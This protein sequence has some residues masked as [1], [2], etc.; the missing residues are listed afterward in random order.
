[1]SLLTYHLSNENL[2]RK[3][4]LVILIQAPRS[5]LNKEMLLSHASGPSEKAALEFL[6]KSQDRTL[7]KGDQFYIPADRS[8]DVLKMLGTTGRLFYQNKKIVIDPFISL[9]LYF[10]TDEHVEGYWKTGNQSGKISECTFVFAADPSWM[11]QDSI[12]RAFSE[13][14]GSKWVRL[15]LEGPKLLTGP[16]LAEFLAEAEGE[17]LIVRK[18]PLPTVADPL[19]V[20]KLVDR[21]GGFANLWFD[22]GPYGS[23]VSHDSSSTP[24]R[25]G[26]AERAWERDLLE[27][28]FQA[29]IVDRSHY[30]C[31]LDK[32]TKSLT[33]L[34]EI[35]WTIFDAQDRKVI[36]QKHCDLDAEITKEHIIVKARLHY[37]QHQVNLKDVVGAFNRR[38]HFVE[39]SSD[40]VA[41]IDRQEIS[42][43][44]GDLMDQ[45]VTSEGIAVKKNRFGLLAP[46]FEGKGWQREDLKQQI[47]QLATAQPS[48]PIALTEVFKGTLFPYQN[49]GL[50]WLHFLQEGRFGG[51][52]ADEM[53]LGKTVQVLAFFSSLKFERP[54]LIV[55]PTSLIFNWHS[56]IEKFLPT[57]QVYRH[58]GKDRLRTKEELSRCSLILTSY[59]LMRIDAS[60][61]QELDYD[62]IVLDEGQT[63]KNPDSQI[64][65]L[66]CQLKADM[67][68]VI[69]GTPIENKLEDIWSLFRFL[70]PDLLGERRSF[71]AEIL[72]AQSDS[73]YL[74]RLKRKIRP[75][76]LRRKK[77]QV[78]LQLPPKLEQTILVEMNED[79]RQIYERWLQNTRKGLLKKVD[80]EGIAQ[81]R[82]EILE[83]IL[84][85]R[86]LCAHPWLIEER[87]E[88]DPRKLS[89]K[90]E[91][92]MTDLQ[93]VM[94]EGSK[95]LVY[96][97]FT[98]MLRLIEQEVK[99]QNWKYV[100]LDGSSAHREQTVRQFQEDP[101]TAIFLISL[102]AGGV[103]LNLTAADYVFLYDPWWNEAVEKQAIDRAHRLGKRGTV[104][105]RR[106]IT[107]LS[108]EEKMM[109]LKTKKTALA[110]NFLDSA[111]ELE[112]VSLEDLLELLN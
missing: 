2:N 5:I 38:E 45:E 21:H 56:E 85:L 58:E 81:H 61:L 44:W 55:V 19:P 15:A 92:L 7:S 77:E 63:I 30:Y 65:E 34:L 27:T 50:Q 88:E 49:E 23:I 8:F 41:L 3:N 22:Y 17:I 52:L 103:G 73:R 29:K 105:A 67:R 95:V 57:C 71:Q 98:Q 4:Y 62:C 109:H 112:A 100:Y 93:E 82:M 40:H 70:L 87:Q 101:E 43:Q 46:L 107:A 94:E 89:A 64:A 86:Q 104:I 59:A 20:L 110:H 83:A 79:Q 18:T 69:T 60:L 47:Q 36:R 53:G 97:Q 48:A 26:D 90:L 51:L 25:K 12:L 14:V 102:K 78:A 106:Y 35:G 10:E 1:M 24:W 108:I 96:S 28:D 91:R 111:E 76:I 37:D 84:R 9:E 39:L 11:I 54:C 99:A 13:E 66:C 42:A 6:F 80:L 32:V 68:L 72:A 33:F 75:F 74:E 31:P 16:K